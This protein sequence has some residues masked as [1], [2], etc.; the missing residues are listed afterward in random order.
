M[1]NHECIIG[2]LLQ[3][4]TSDLCTVSILR[5]HIEERREINEFAIKYMPDLV[6][7]EWTMKD[8]ADRRKSTNLTHFTFCPTCG[9]KIDWKEL[10]EKDG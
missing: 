7:P 2:L 4:E 5:R 3:T 6:S 10:R 9:K 8:Y 1:D